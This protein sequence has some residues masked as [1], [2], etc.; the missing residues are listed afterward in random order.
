MSRL[1]GI[2]M[3]AGRASSGSW[4]RIGGRSGPDLRGGKRGGVGANDR[5]DC[6]SG[7]FTTTSL[8]ARMGV[9][10]RGGNAGLL[11]SD[12][13]DCLLHNSAGW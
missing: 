13:L 8:S 2:G 9:G 6:S 12:M 3:L 4:I 7:E 10:R 11:I 5:E 1:D